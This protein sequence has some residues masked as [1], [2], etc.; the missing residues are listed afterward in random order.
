MDFSSIAT[1]LP[2]TSNAMPNSTS[3]IFVVPP[4]SVPSF[5]YSTQP[6][7]QAQM[8]CLLLDV[9]AGDSHYNPIHISSLRNAIHM[10]RINS[11]LPPPPPPISAHNAAIT[12]CAR[13]K[14]ITD[15]R[16]NQLPTILSPSVRA[17]RTVPCTPT[18]KLEHKPCAPSRLTHPSRQSQFSLDKPRRGRKRIDRSPF[19]NA[20]GRY[21]CQS[22]D[23]SYKRFNDLKGHWNIHDA[24]TK[25][26]PFC[27][28]KFSRP[29][30]LKDH[31]R[32]HTGEKPYECVLCSKK[33]S[34]KRNLT[35]HL[36]VHRS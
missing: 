19:L 4:V 34:A 24:S 22:C 27:G 20:A 29:V 2:L 30:Y 17:V 23:R 18:P 10:N 13:I 9:S 35:Q 5:T 25:G 14:T 7:S 32:S 31:I 26:C 3:Y 8:P 15:Q 16:N 28:K 21:Q 36:K 11:T 33:F 12:T 1:L 6:S